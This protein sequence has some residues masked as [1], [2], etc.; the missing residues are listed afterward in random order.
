MKVKVTQY[1]DDGYTLEVKDF[2][3]FKIDIELDRSD[4]GHIVSPKG[5]VV[6]PLNNFESLITITY[7]EV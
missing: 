4:L 5:A 3:N 7:K 6:E 2:I 1:D